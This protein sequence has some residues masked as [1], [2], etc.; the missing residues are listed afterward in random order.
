MLNIKIGADPE[1]FVTKGGQFRSAHGL[2]PGTKEKPFPVE[3]GAVQ[4]DGMAL[5]YNIDPATTADEFVLYNQSVLG[6]LKAMVP[7]YEFAIVPS[8]RFNGNHFRVQPDEAKELGC[9]RNPTTRRLRG[10][11]AATSISVSSIRVTPIRCRM[12]T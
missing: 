5:E 9:T 4:V 7:D 10:L 6:Q 8:C 11:R 12:T 2:I 3:N 1:L